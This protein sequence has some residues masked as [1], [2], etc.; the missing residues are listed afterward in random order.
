MLLG[1]KVERGRE[2]RVYRQVADVTRA[3]LPLML[4]TGVATAAIVD[5]D[6][7]EARLRDEAVRLDATIVAPPLIGAWARNS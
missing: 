6:T 2:A 4:R 5:I 1:A 3:V 7:L